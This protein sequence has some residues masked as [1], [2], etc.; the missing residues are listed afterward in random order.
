MVTPR[1]RIPRPARL[2]RMKVIV[3][4]GNP[5]REYADTR[6]NAGWWLVDA[7][8][9]RWHFDAWKKEGESL[10]STGLV[11]TGASARKVR[12]V[13]PQ[14]YMNLS[15]G[16]LRPYLKRDGFDIAQDL[17]V[18]VDELAIP[19]GQFRFRAAGSAGGHNGLKSVE[20]HTKT[21]AYPRLRI[22]IRPVDERRE[23]GVM[24]DFVLHTMPRDER[25][26]V[27]GVFEKAMQAVELW[28]AEGTEKAVSTMGR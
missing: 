25:E 10:V 24:S 5:G 3:G 26:L 17:L 9:R 28:I 14:T 18:I 12:I 4:L 11:G 13:K 19:A 27:E 21:Q 6:H 22:G 23:I 2:P 20:A 8:A 1:W 15:G 7:L 16:V